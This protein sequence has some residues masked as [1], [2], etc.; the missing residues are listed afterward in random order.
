MAAPAPAQAE[1]HGVELVWQH[2]EAGP[3]EDVLLRRVTAELEL[4]GFEVWVAPERSPSGTTALGRVTLRTNPDA[5]PTLEWAPRPPTTAPN[6]SVPVPP[7]ED[8]LEVAAVQLAELIVA[9][10]EM[11]PPP[12]VSEPEPS[13]PA[14]VRPTEPPP[15][16]WRIELGPSGLVSPGGLGFLLGPHLSL[17][18][19]LGER[20][21]F[22]LGVDGS[23]SALTARVRTAEREHRIGVAAIRAH[24]LWWPRPSGRLSPA[25]GLGAGT[26]LAWSTPGGTTAVGV[27]S[28]R[29]DLAFALNRT[30][31]IWAGA[32][33][34]VAVPQ[35]EVRSVDQTLASGGR[36]LIDLAVGI[37]LRG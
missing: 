36:P 20:R 5:L 27:V 4:R 6:E 31:A 32:R 7:G 21:R 29:G 18:S 2:D 3:R 28:A 10:A 35:I 19:A 1:R 12:V 33:L 37:Q 11:P 9:V 8:A 22:G 24:A 13:P 16:R 17:S 15:T 25:L 14:P 26:L 30:V 34:D 23:A